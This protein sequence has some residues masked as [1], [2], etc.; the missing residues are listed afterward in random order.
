MVN[1][2]VVIIG[3]GHWGDQH[4][5]AF[6][7]R[8]DVEL[9]GIFSRSFEHAA[10]RAAK[11][12]TRPYTDVAQMLATEKPDLV[13]ICLPNQDHFEVTR[14]VIRLGYPLLVE[15]PLVFDL[16]EADIL[17]EEARRKNLF[18]AIDFNHRYARPIQQALV[19]IERGRLGEIVFA[20]WRFGGEGWSTH[21][22]GNL[23]ETQC[24]AFDQLEHLC[25]PID[26]IMAQMT[27]QQQ[28]GGFTTVAL[29]LQF[30]SGA[31]GS[32]L[33]TYDSSY[34]YPG[35]HLLEINGTKGRIFIEDTV[36][37]YSFQAAGSETAEVWQA[38]YFNDRD[39]EFAST[40]DTYVEALLHAFLAGQPPPVPAGAGRRTLELA[41][42]A[43]AS[44]E[45]GQRVKVPP[46]SAPAAKA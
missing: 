5:R 21:P 24:H 22:H 39:R 16:E 9:A 35:A 20:W 12:G 8:A 14:E 29:A 7:A 2:K 18:F 26:S 44:F 45:T 31:V 28:R 43:I 1:L 36:R 33:G 38:G 41:L 15:K 40:F 19:A 30:V 25:G 37:R 3:A 13:S 27:G 46:V 32:I 4:A 34:A 10:A 42:A 23:I 11:H 17:I 6:A